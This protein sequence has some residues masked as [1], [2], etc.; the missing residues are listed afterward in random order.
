M[1]DKGWIRKHD[2]DWESFVC[3]PEGL[4]RFIAFGVGGESV[5]SLGSHISLANAKNAADAEV[6]SLGGHTCSENCGAWSK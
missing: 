6:A 3:E 5:R 4:Q 1:P 2:N